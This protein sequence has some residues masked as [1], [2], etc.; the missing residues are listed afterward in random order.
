MV[1]HTST[2]KKSDVK[3]T[4]ITYAAKF[5]YQVLILLN[6]SKYTALIL[7]VVFAQLSPQL[8]NKFLS[9]TFSIEAND[10]YVFNYYFYTYI[11]Y[12]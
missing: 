6:E 2:K 1:D 8:D 11:I 5:Y 4:T 9:S 7:Q 10:Y 3:V 12:M